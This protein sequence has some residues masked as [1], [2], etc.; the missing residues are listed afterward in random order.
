MPQAISPGFP[1]WRTSESMRVEHW[2]IAAQH[3]RIAAFNMAGTP[4]KFRGVPVF[5]SMQY[6]FPIRYVG[7]AT[8]WD[9]VII[10]GSLDERKFIAFY[11]KDDRVLAAASSKRDTETAA[12]AELLRIDKMPAPNDL[13]EGQFNHLYP[14]LLSDRA[15][16]K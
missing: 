16:S 14:D 12:I 13:R 15:M 2:R 5:W 7:H 3:G 9:E 8:E 4:T 11:V 1:D 10:D 6:Q